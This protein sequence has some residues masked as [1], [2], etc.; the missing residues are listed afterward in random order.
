VDWLR[1]L[2]PLWISYIAFAALFTLVE[3]VWPARTLRYRKT[4]LRDVV[5]A[6]VYQ[7]G[8]LTAATYVCQP[9]GDLVV[10]H[11]SPTVADLWLAPRVVVYYLAADFGSYWMHRL[12]HTHQLW[13]IH[14]WHHSPVQLYWLAGARASL[15][16][17][18]LFNLPTLASLPILAGA[19]GWV[20]MAI[21]IE[22]MFRNDW[23]HAN[24]AWRSRW[25]ELV[26][27]TPRYHHIHHS[28][29]AEQHDG[30]YGSL[31]T[32]WDRLFGTYLDPDTTRAQK[33][34]TGEPPR[35]PVW[36]ALGV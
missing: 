24:L 29:D 21:L 1:E 30:N 12:M 15:P 3:L 22:G 17:Q 7:F 10:A 26:F 35:D 23:M 4:L 8:V 32:L 2:H 36:L 31:F 25:L 16:Q 27:V 13:R 5:A 20:V 9:I 6:L 28:T 34:G 14:R 19:P 33:F 11:L 18:I